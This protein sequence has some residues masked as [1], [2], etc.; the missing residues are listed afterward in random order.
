[1]EIKIA[2]NPDCLG[3]AV[4]SRLER[5]VRLALHTCSARIPQVIVCLEDL[6][7]CRGLWGWECRIYARLLPFGA[8]SVVG[9]GNDAAT[10]LRGAAELLARSLL[11][12]HQPAGGER[13][14][15]SVA[16]K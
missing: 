8:K 15:G 12:D 13:L 7:A 2:T 16:D 3:A 9:N 5:L 4:R 11:S 6:D 1:M 10:A 14:L